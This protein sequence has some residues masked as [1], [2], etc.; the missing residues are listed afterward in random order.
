VLD[1][2]RVDP[3]KLGRPR[4]EPSVPICVKVPPRQY[5]DLYRRAQ[6]QRVS[7]PE[8]IRQSLLRYPK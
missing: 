1:C 6:E 2:C 8:V 7:V 4:R 3:K 5:D